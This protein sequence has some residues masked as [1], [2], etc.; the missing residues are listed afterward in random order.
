MTP[1]PTN[2]ETTRAIEVRRLIRVMQEEPPSTSFNDQ[3]GTLVKH[4]AELEYQMDNL[5]QRFDVLFEMVKNRHG[6]DGD[7]E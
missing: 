1:T 3:L 5:N 7:D 6:D 2:N 4:V